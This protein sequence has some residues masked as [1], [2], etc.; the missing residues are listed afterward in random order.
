MTQRPY[1]FL[2][3][4]QQCGKALG[5]DAAVVFADDQDIVLHYP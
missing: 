3:Q 2:L 5:S 4:T 1:L